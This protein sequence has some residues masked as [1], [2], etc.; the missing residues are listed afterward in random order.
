MKYD[1]LTN[2]L[3]KYLLGDKKT[4]RPQLIDVYEHGKR[5]AHGTPKPIN[6]KWQLEDKRH[7]HPQKF[8]RTPLALHLHDHE[9]F[10]YRNNRSSGLVLLKIDI[11]AHEG[12]TDVLAV[13]E[14]IEQFYFP[15]CY[16]EPSTGGLGRH[17]YV[18]I[19]FNEYVPRRRVNQWLTCMGIALRELMAAQGYQAKV[20]PRTCR[21]FSEWGKNAD[22]ARVANKMGQFSKI[23]RP[24]TLDQ[25]DEIESSP[26]YLPSAVNTVIDDY[27]R[28]RAAR[29]ERRVVTNEP[30][31]APPSAAVREAVRK[32][33]GSF[34]GMDHADP[35]SRAVHAVM[36]L[37]RRLG[38]MPSVT[39]ARIFY[40]ASGLATVRA[41]GDSH[42]DVRRRERRLDGAIVHVAKTFDEAKL[43][44]GFQ[45]EAMLQIVREHVQPHHRTGTKY[46]YGITDEDLAIALHV[47]E[48][49]SFE[50]KI[51]RNQQWTLPNA[52]LIG[53]FRRLKDEGQ[54]TLINNTCVPAR[55]ERKNEGAG[56]NR[57]KAVALKLILTRAGLAECIDESY[58]PGS[59]RVRRTAGTLINNTCVPAHSERKNEGVDPEVAEAW[60]Q[61]GY[62]GRGKRYVVGHHHPRRQEWE[63]EYEQLAEWVLTGRSQTDRE[64][65]E[66]VA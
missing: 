3:A 47:V 65:V 50:R 53:T 57:Q 1:E 27:K 25:M 6:L 10:Y 56:C 29:D 64:L 31:D 22:G 28:L 32:A 21:T 45:R 48:L 11:D 46:Q 37:A 61:V 16:H 35:R 63:S 33:V 34:K 66:R 23:P 41:G 7:G 9:T 20:D 38:R 14:T 54:D 24:R 26:W 58:R 36:A 52:R 44:H 15:S 2:R 40:E 55:S 60:G 5:D 19:A 49:A 39:E 30:V 8:T 13:A 4:G 12:Q 51:N 62:E 42:R 18:V 17:L 59:T 43:G